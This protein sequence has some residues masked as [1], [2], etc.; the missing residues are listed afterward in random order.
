MVPRF[1]QGNGKCQKT[2]CC[3]ERP[4]SFW[5]SIYFF[6]KGAVCC[7]A[8]QPHPWA[9]LLWQHQLCSLAHFHS[10]HSTEWLYLTFP[11]SCF[12]F[13]LGGLGFNYI[14]LS[15]ECTETTGTCCFLWHPQTHRCRTILRL[16]IITS[17]NLKA[18][19]SI[20]NSIPHPTDNY[21]RTRKKHNLS[22]VIE[23]VHFKKVPYSFQRIALIT[24]G[25][26]CEN[27]HSNKRGAK[28]ELIAVF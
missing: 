25:E 9:T 2:Q 3:P 28:L 12:C 27:L 21:P 13:T 8:W 20:W 23:V 24:G 7:Q 15:I 6:W 1:R 14:E 5:Q 26:F 17:P 22:L 11:M 10:L 19:Q 4:S 16:K 18:W